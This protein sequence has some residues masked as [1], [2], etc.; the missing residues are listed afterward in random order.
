MAYFVN[1]S[2]EP[3]MKV[4][5][6]CKTTTLTQK[7]W[8]YTFQVEELYVIWIISPKKGIFYFK[9]EDTKELHPCLGFSSNPIFLSL[10]SIPWIT[11]HNELPACKPWFR[12]CFLGRRQDGHRRL[13][14]STFLL[15]ENSEQWHHYQHSHLGRHSR[16][17]PA[18]LSCINGIKTKPHIHSYFLTAFLLED[19]MNPG[20]YD[21]TY[22]CSLQSDT[23]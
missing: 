2:F 11:L 23:N 10:E 1:K 8:N 13:W 7:L 21:I 5:T 22:T 3:E 15:G 20:K 17:L 16:F 18:L 6:F 4:K 19:F 9:N 14:G 12:L